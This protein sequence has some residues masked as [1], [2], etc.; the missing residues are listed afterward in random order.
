MQNWKKEVFSIPNL[1]SMFR[2]L[3]I[4]VYTTLFLQAQDRTDYWIAAGIL[5]LSSFTDLI[6]GK[7]ARRFNMIT[8]V[9]IV[10][11]PIAD[12]A[13]QCTL[14]ICLSIRHSNLWYVFGLF[15]VKE[16]FMLIMGLVNLRKRKMLDG[17]LFS[18]KVCTAILF[19]SMIILVLFPDITPGAVDV[20]VCAC[21]I[22][23]LV[24]F[25][26]YI[27]AYFG[28]DKKVRDL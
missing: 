14:L 12:K 9:G 4:P 27:N 8:R 17:A 5:A 2:L 28:K 21:M 13:T 22:A 19:V 1:L 26:G 7:I 3:L 25:A 10:L 6:D 23:L 24:A 16:T 15:V 11:D 20:L 18:G